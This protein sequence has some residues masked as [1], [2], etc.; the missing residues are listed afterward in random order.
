MKDSPQRTSALVWVIDNYDSFVHN[1]AR[2]IQLCGL[3][4]RIMRN[5]AI[6]WAALDHSPPACIVLSP[7]PSAPQQAGDL[8][9]LIKHAHQYVPMLGICLGHQA[10]AQALGA[11]ITH[12]KEPLHGMASPLQHDALFEFSS[13]PQNTAV[14]RYH[15]LIVEPQSVPDVLHISARSTTGEIM[16]L[17]HRH[18]PVVGWQ[19]HP[20]SILTEHGSLMLSNF[21][22]LILAQTASPEG[23]DP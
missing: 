16:A 2:Y 12:A 6:D 15:S 11:R 7:G 5:D 9:R 14:G 18:L 1:L 22:R 20:E 13:C 23:T 19:F 3:T 4:T 8:L 10:I 17:R 21:F